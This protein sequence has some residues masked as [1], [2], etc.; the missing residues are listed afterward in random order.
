MINGTTPALQRFGQ[1]LLGIFPLVSMFLV[2]SISMFPR[3]NIRFPRAAAHDTSDEVPAARRLRRRLRAR[4]NGPGRRAVRGCDLVP[5]PAHRRIDRARS[6]ARRTNAVLGMAMGL[7]LSAFTST[8]FQAVQFM[9]AFVL[10][11]LLLCGIAVP[12]RPHGGTL[13][14]AVRCPADDL[15]VQGLRDVAGL[16]RRAGEHA[17]RGSRRRCAL[18]GSRASPTRPPCRANRL[19]KR[20]ALRPRNASPA[21]AD[22][23]LVGS[24]RA[25]PGHG[26]RRHTMQWSRR[27][28][29][30]EKM[31]RAHSGCS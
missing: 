1:P 20:R 22:D 31:P 23:P 5:R 8:E 25:G 29:V 11:Q 13:A 14:A 4:G 7:F 19:S 10:P 24:E 17:L 28:H 27:R 30:V 2:T 9:P 21:A 12:P 26:R 3:A 18:D 6:L 15:R 16:Q